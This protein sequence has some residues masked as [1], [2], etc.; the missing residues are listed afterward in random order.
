MMAADFSIHVLCARP[1]G[2]LRWAAVALYTAA[3]PYVILVFQALERHFPATIT[4]RLPLLITVLL[5]AVYTIVCVQQKI[6]IRCLGILAVSALI[7]FTIVMAE[8]N[9][10]KHIHIPQYVLMTWLLYWALATDYKGRGLLLLI[11]TCAAM[12]GFVDELMQGIHP[13]RSYGW[14]DMVI[15]AAAAFIGVLMLMGMTGSAVQKRWVWA[16]RWRDYRGSLMLILLSGATAAVMGV[17]L[18]DVQRQGAFSPSYPGW[19]LIG[20]G[21]S[22]GGAVAVIIYY[23]NRGRVFAVSA[24]ET[25][26]VADDDQGTIRRWIFSLLAILAVMHALVLWAVVAGLNFK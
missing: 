24:T 14:S 6:A 21:L 1:P 25:D 17:R 16:G 12:L 20:N 15:D 10:N 3:L 8:P 18:F 4:A 19:L 5:A 26:P 11:F 13:Q 9:G 23:W 7:V 2:P 22:L